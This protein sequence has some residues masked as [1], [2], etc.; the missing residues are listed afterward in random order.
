MSTFLSGGAIEE[1]SLGCY[2][3]VSSEE[4]KLKQT[5]E[6]QRATME[7]YLT[8][9]EVTPFSWY[10]DDGVTG[11][12][13]LMERPEGAR[14]MADARA[15][16]VKT[17]LVV[18]LD[19]FGRNARHIL[20]TVHELMGAGCRLV[21]IAEG[22]DTDTPAGW[23]QMQMLAAIA[24]YEHANILARAGAGYARRLEKTAWMGGRPPVGYRVE[25]RRETAHLVI[26]ETPDPTTGYSEADVVRLCYPLLVER[27]WTLTQIA[28]HLSELGIP[29]RA[30][31]RGQTVYKLHG[32]ELPLALMWAP[33]VVYHMLTNPIY[34]G[35]RSVLTKDGRAVTH[36]ATALVDVDV[37]ERAQFMLVDHRRY[38]NRNTD[39]EYLLR[40]MMRCALCGAPYTTSW[41][42]R[43]ET[44]DLWRYYACSP[45]H[46]RSAIARRA[47]AH[48][49]TG[50]PPTCVGKAISAVHIEEVVWRA[51]ARFIRSPGEA[52]H[53]LA[54]QVG[55]QAG[56][57]ETQRE[58]LARIQAE[59]DTYQSQRDAVVALFRRGRISE[60]DLD[61]QLD[62]ITREE[63]GVHHER[64]RIM[65]ALQTA[66]NA[67]DRLTG[68]RTLLQQLHARL[69]SEPI[70][71]ELQRMAVETIIAGIWVVTEEIGLST[72]GKVKR[73]ARVI[74]TYCFDNPSTRDPPDASRSSSSVREYGEAD[75]QNT[76]GKPS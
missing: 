29:T 75:D 20:N 33:G 4:Q 56:A 19:R 61:R 46:F 66:N 15:G 13:S 23:L 52:L 37:W 16:Q 27:N 26:D 30:Q 45:R 62:D 28:D 63:S 36:P 25:G 24:E 10:L 21:S 49:Q 65:A 18:R 12:V 69:D 47:R 44:G 3:R 71:P 67:Q 76:P 57:A 8:L 9:H 68:A 51:V 43:R 41:T 54:A 50:E 64:E 55:S 59:L 31:R 72:R 48:G 60:R 40:G 58:R 5:I 6:N 1:S 74:V 32:A 70:T 14:L 17:V 39:R 7:R 35:I 73:R 38:S 34:K 2:L 22:F 11:T 53:L 42:K